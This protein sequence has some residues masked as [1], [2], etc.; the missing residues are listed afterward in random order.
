MSVTLGLVLTERNARRRRAPDPRVDVVM[1]ERTLL[2]PPR[3]GAA[4]RWAQQ[5]QRSFPRARLLPLAWHLVTHGPEDRMRERSTRTLSGPPHLFGGLQDNAQIQQA[6]DVTRLCANAMQSNTVVL[7]T[8]PSITPGALGRARIRAFAEVRRAEG[9]DLVWE[10]E[11]LWEA[12]VAA[13]LAREVGIT[14][15]LPA[16]A[17][18][19]PLRNEQG[20]GLAA[21]GA[22]LRVDIPR[23]GTIH[24]GMID[25]LL[26]HAEVAADPAIVFSG[27]RARNN[28]AT[29]ADALEL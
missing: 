18:G 12:P 24:G 20:N 9:I 10:P 5:V 8:P 23:E 3:A 16:F 4:K 21:P 25:E 29:F 1:L 22:W 7:R 11:G 14:V 17:G 27:A 26:D 13:A 28:L 2:D 6:W 19:R 15:M